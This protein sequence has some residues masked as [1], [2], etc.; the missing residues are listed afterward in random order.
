MR[1]LLIPG[2]M[3]LTLGG[4]SAHV[5]A[6][7]PASERLG[8]IKV[9]SVRMGA[10][11]GPVTV[12]MGDG[13]V[14]TG[15][16]WGTYS[17]A[18]SLGFANGGDLGQSEPRAFGFSGNA[19]PRGLRIND[20]PVHFVVNGPKTKILCRGRSGSMGYGDA[21]CQTIDGAWWVIYW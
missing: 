11:H 21:E 5:I 20:G 18:Q 1:R 16:Y 4:C 6:M 10:T 17:L 9:S 15:E 12:K 7:N 2:V 8:P 19:S 14:L 3:V 13:E